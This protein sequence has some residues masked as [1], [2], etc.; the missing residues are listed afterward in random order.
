MSHQYCLVSRDQ[1][2]GKFWKRIPDYSFALGA[3]VATIAAE[4]LSPASSAFPLA[5]V[6]QEERL[7]L[8]ALLG[9]LP[10]QS[11]FVGGA[12]HWL[13]GYVPSTIRSYPF[14]LTHTGDGEVALCIDEDSGWIVPPSPNAVPFFTDIGDPHPE[15][16]KML[17][18]LVAM[19][20]GIAKL[21]PAVELLEREEL[22]EPWP[23]DVTND[24][25]TKQITG[26]LR[27][28]ETA[29]N[30]LPADRFI[31][32]RDTSV[33]PVAYAQLLSMHNIAKLKRLIGAGMEPK[34]RFRLSE[35]KTIEFS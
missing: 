34:P 11:C 22:L 30:A 1:H 26:M 6:M 13:G 33:L 32:L 28:N 23:I 35:Q 12:G 17:Q 25:G 4:E 9:L 10:G 20:N 19:E 21:R 7:T 18:M 14:R 29:L 31:A 3:N 8:V 24:E 15:T 5:F 16:T 27:V 2:A